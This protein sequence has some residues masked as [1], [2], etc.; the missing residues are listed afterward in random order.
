S[1]HRACASSPVRSAR[2]SRSRRSPTPAPWARR[3][4]CCRTTVATAATSTRWSTSSPDV[5]DTTRA[6]RPASPTGIARF[7]P[8]LH[9]GRHY[10]RPTL[11]GDLTAGLTVAV[12]LVPQAMAYAELAGMPPVT[13]LYAAIVAIVAYALLGTSGSLAVGPVAITSLLTLSGLR[14]VVAPEDPTYPAVAALLA[15]S[16][17]AVLVVAGLLRLGFVVDFLSRPVI[18]GF[19]SAAAITIALS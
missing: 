15:V 13:G 2:A 10:R 5:P 1:G 16:V 12:M 18:S 9:W 14:S 3:C 4:R 6:P 7:L 11:R 19:T 8:I 17:G